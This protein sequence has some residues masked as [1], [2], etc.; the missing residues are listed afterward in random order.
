MIIRLS[1]EEYPF[2]SLVVRDKC[3]ICLKDFGDPV[4]YW[5][6]RK[7]HEIGIDLE[8]IIKTLETP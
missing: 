7:T 5:E 2:G 1:E 3:P 4:E 8:S 6:H